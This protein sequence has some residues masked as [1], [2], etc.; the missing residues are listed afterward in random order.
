[1]YFRS[2]QVV[3][4]KCMRSSNN[5][6]PHMSQTVGVL[7]EVQLTRSLKNIDILLDSEVEYKKGRLIDSFLRKSYRRHQ[8]FHVLPTPHKV[9]LSKSKPQRQQCPLHLRLPYIQR[10]YSIFIPTHNPLRAPYKKNWSFSKS[11]SFCVPWKMSIPST[12]SWAKGNVW[13]G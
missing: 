4:L 6:C 2:E 13:Y 1:M 8:E 3:V 5:H 7:Y 11:P 10:W 9:T 12:R